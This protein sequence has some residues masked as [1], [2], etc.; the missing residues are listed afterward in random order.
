MPL[1]LLSLGSNLGDRRGILQAA[2][3]AF[4][5]SPG[6]RLM[7]VSRWHETQPIGGPGGQSNFLNG[8]ALLET[9]LS[10]LELLARLQRIE[11]HL[12]RR[13]DERWAART[14]DLDLLLYEDV[15]LES[16][17]LVLP[18]PR[19]AFRRFA[20][21]PAVEVA[22]QMV[23]PR[24]GWT[25]RRLWEHLNTALPYVAIGRHPAIDASELM[26]AIALRMPARLIFVDGSDSG[27]NLERQSRQL[28]E[29]D[30]PPPPALTISDFW[31]DETLCLSGAT[32]N[33]PLPARQSML[34]PKLV[35]CSESAHALVQRCV[36]DLGPWLRLSEDDAESNLREAIAALQAMQ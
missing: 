10:P 14:L 31:L 19:M 3:S 29:L 36:S 9:A 28:L 16:P 13:R 21:A 2:L 18:H 5:N 26:Q 25:V 7:A 11:S 34:P 12:G 1:A 33:K 23:H 35:L 32:S 6:L 8:A 20:L 4:G 24:L 30:W 22:P 27:A 17:Q 15:V